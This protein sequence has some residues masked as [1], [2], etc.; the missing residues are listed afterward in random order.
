M[1]CLRL[2][3]L[4]L[5][6]GSL[7]FT[8]S[9]YAAASQAVATGHPLAT[10][11]AVDAINRG[12]NAIDGTIAAALTLGVVDGHNS[13]IGGGCFLLIRTAD[14][15]FTAI[16]G[17]EMA[18]ASAKRDMYVRGGKLDAT[19]SQHGPL[20]V[21]IPGA[22][23]A[24]EHA[25]HR[26]GKLSLSNHL[27]TA[28][29]LAERGFEINRSYGSA[30]AATADELRQNEAA[31]AIFFAKDG[32]PLKRGETLKQLDLARTYRN[33]AR[34]GVDWFYKG[35]FANKTAQWMSTNGGIITATD[36]ANYRTK[37]R[38]PLYTTYRGY[39]I[40]G[41]PP[42]SSGGV[43]VG[44]I[45][46]IIERFTLSPTG[47]VHV[48]AEAMKL[49]FADRA[50]WLGDP[51]FAAVPRGLVDKEYAAKLA[52]RINKN[53]TVDVAHHSSPPD[54][55]ENVF[56]TRASH[57]THFC[58]ADAEGNWVACT[59]TINTSFGSKVI[60][61]GTGVV[62]NNEMDDFS[63]QPGVAN[64]FGLVGGEANAIQPGKRPLSSMSPTIVLKDG[65]PVFSVGAAGGPTIIS[66]VALAVIAVVDFG[67]SP[68][69]ALAQPRFHHQWKPDELRIEESFGGEYLLRLG[70]MGHSVKAVKSFGAAQA[71]GL[72]R[73]GALTAAPDPRGEGK[74]IAW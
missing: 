28:A 19:L 63:L 27:I 41:F 1:H 34:L 56:E 58:V 38:E 2:I 48:V 6:S 18:P 23:A 70:R 14:G 40:V 51:D 67:M 22:L 73:S 50:H 29:A 10:Q 44:Q 35:E 39:D 43:H 62:L 45:L 9:T 26:F 31:R 59:A 74:A 7:L 64:F 71:I 12:G 32:S 65:K 5:V 36:F 30:L 42:P 4:L 3:T 20:A 46:N 24:Y 52:A 60:I 57:T 13:G 54:A 15:T 33:I 17:R 8:A 55:T 21:A 66:Q 16:D 25:A 61:P 49:A 37:I 69:E 72:S 68:E 47:Y 53:F 11:A